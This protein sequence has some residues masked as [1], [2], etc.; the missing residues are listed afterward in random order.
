MKFDVEVENAK[1]IQETLE[2]ISKLVIN[3]K[4]NALKAIGLDGQTVVMLHSPVDTGRLRNSANHKVEKDVVTIGVNVE[5]APKLE[6]SGKHKGW[7]TRAYNEVNK[8]AQTIFRRIG[9]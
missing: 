1:L 5:Y 8:R 9:V 3:N 4:D 7:F 6:F 2:K